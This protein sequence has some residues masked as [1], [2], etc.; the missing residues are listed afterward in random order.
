MTE[1]DFRPM[2]G[3]QVMAYIIKM[4]KEVGTPYN[5]D[6]APKAHVLLRRRRAGDV[7]E[8]ALQRATGGMAIWSSVPNSSQVHSIPRNRRR[9]W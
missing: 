5:R 7:W 1:F 8:A 4:C 3:L 2:N 9:D 6:Q